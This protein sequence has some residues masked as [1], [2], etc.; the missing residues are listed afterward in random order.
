MP[1]PHFKIKVTQRSKGQSAVAGAAYQSGDNLFSEYDQRRKNYHNKQGILHAEILLPSHVPREYADREK[2]W[3]SV[4]EIENQWNSQLARRFVVALPREVPAEM[5][6]EMVR[7]YC[8]KFFVEKGMICDFAIHNTENDNPHVHIML[9][10]RAMDENGKWMPKSKKVYDLDSDGN[11]IRLPSGNWKS[12]KENTV[13]WNEQSYAEIWRSGW[14]DIQNKYLELNNRQERVD[15]RS[16]KRQ[17]ID[18]VPTVHMGASVTQME[19]RGIETNVGNLNRDIQ[20]INRILYAIRK[21]I[22]S[23]TS[24]IAEFKESAKERQSDHAE[25]NASPY[26]GELLNR[27]MDLRKEERSGW[28][29]FGQSKGNI[30]DMKA[31]SKAIAYLQNNKLNSLDELDAKIADIGARAGAVNKSIRVAERRIR[32]IAQIQKSIATCLENKDIRDKY[33]RIGWKTRKAL[34][35]ESHKEEI[36]AYNKSFR[37]L[38]KMG[39][40][41]NA[42]IS[43]LKKESAVLTKTIA[44]NKEKLNAINEELKPLKQVR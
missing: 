29:K 25:Q 36:D 40:E 38:K 44:D 27:Y 10:L 37:L 6:P 24:W 32:D 39:V 20:S 15:L 21:K 43:G 3:N 2:L 7:E 42:D 28:S 17:G 14:A 12:H 22:K 19:R 9:T 8:E 4:E 26:L 35:Y 5:Y 23:L 31:V 41:L 18:K 33:A 13:D 34:Y 30:A 16:Y 11:R 1:N